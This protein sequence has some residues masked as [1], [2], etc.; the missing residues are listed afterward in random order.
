M[1]RGFGLGPDLGDAPIPSDDKRA[2]HD[3]QK[4]FAEKLL[5]APRVV[6]FD[7]LELRIAQQREVEVEFRGE[8]CLRRHAIGAAAQ[9]DRA[10]LIELWFGVA[11]LGRFVDSTGSVGFGIEIENQV[12]PAIIRERDDF[13]VIGLYAK[14]W[15]LVAFFQHAVY[16]LLRSR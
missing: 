11:K 12:P 2:A 10:S 15:S 6:G 4:R 5:H 1:T 16:S 3:A 9:D 8:L 13:A 7:G 14:A